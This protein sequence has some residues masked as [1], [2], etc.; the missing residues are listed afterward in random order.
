MTLVR[1]TAV[2][3]TAAGAA[4][5]LLAA[6]APAQARGKPR[7]IRVQGPTYVYAN[8]AFRKVR[9]SAHV[10]YGR[11]ST[12]VR[13]RATGFPRSAVGKALG[14][15]VHKNRCGRRPADA[16]P[17]YQNPR[18]A[19]N[20]PLRAKEI[21]LDF[22]VRRDRTAYGETRVPWRVARGQAGSIVIHAK[23]TDR[24]T[25][26]AGDRLVCTNVPF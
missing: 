20:A 1:R 4:L 25:G 15:H 19:R 18:A 26:D 14:V 11:N 17:H 2:T 9:T 23:P 6:P 21:W 3:L 5:A 7:D 13:F 12:V 8:P 16:G 22:K 24:R 10:S